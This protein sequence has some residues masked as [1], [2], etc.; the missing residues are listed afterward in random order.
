MSRNQGTVSI[1]TNKWSDPNEWSSMIWVNVPHESTRI[2]D[3]ILAKQ[4]NKTTKSG[5]LLSDMM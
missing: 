2:N 5:A 1:E 3:K 4:Q